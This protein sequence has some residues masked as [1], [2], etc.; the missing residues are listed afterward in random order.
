MV[1]YYPD[2][3]AVTD[4]VTFGGAATGL[5]YITDPTTIINGTPTDNGC[6]DG[7]TSLPPDST[8]AAPT[9]P[10]GQWAGSFGDD[11][12]VTA[13]TSANTAAGDSTSGD[14]GG[15]SGTGTG[16]SSGTG[17][18]GSSG[19]GTGG[20]GTGGSAGTGTGGSGTGT[21]G[22]SG[23]GTGGSNGT[24][25]GGS[26]GTASGGGSSGGGSS[27]GSSGGDKPHRPR[28]TIR[29]YVPRVG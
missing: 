14:T 11:E 22:S 21:G 1:N 6:G 29:V 27:G 25:T 5:T 4:T 12:G 19:T 26:S 18:G 20:S 17:T 13:A 10:E 16:G 2:T 7:C 15:S 24:D 9:T 23:T 3:G 8:L 28:H